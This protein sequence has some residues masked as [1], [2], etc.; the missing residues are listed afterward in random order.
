V[1]KGCSPAAAGL[2]GSARLRER[3][4]ELAAAGRPLVAGLDQVRFIDSAWL[5][6]LAGTAKRAAAHSSSPH[7]DNRRNGAR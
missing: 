7:V 5:A 6:A 3:L 2:P 4:F 1:V